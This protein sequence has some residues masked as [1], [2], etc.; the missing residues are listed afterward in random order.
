MVLGDLG[1]GAFL[2]VTD[3]RVAPE[4]SGLGPFDLVHDAACV[5]SD[6]TRFAEVICSVTEHFGELPFVF[7]RAEVVRV[8]RMR[9]DKLLQRRRFLPVESEDVEQVH[10]DAHT[11]GGLEQWIIRLPHHDLQVRSIQV[12][13]EEGVAGVWHIHSA[14]VG[15][16]KRHAATFRF[17]A[18]LRFLRRDR[19]Q[20]HATAESILGR[21]QAIGVGRGLAAGSS[22]DV[23][24]ATHPAVCVQTSA[25]ERTE[26]YAEGAQ[27]GDCTDDRPEQ[28]LA[29]HNCLESLV[30]AGWMCG[31]PRLRF[32]VNDR[33]PQDTVEKF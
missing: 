5:C 30:V 3:A 14:H 19:L 16:N 27:V 13:V 23:I 26:E 8:L 33:L 29:F 1:D 21:G 15:E 25:D 32:G 24:R 6:S 28:W 20:I 9:L 4:V 7:V 31:L 22:G 10:I 2:P 17:T 11:Q 18:T 12:H